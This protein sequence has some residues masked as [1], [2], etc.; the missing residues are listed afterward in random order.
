MTILIRPAEPDD[1]EFVLDGWVSS[2]RNAHA[3]GLI[4]MTNYH[5]VQ[6]A[7][8]EEILV[9]PYVRTL[10]ACDSEE[11]CFCYGFLVYESDASPPY[12]Y[13]VYTKETFRRGAKLDL[14]AGVATELFRAAGIDPARTFA[15]ACKTP[16]V[17]RLAAKI[18][19]ARWNPLPARYEREPGPTV[20]QR[21][22]ARQN[23]TRP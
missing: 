8:C 15:F 19:C 14:G 21:R 3:A 6:W 4:L 1:R 9:R 17:T 18:P 20:E 2:Y 12:V 11:P 10:V 23:G 5:D 22:P 7:Q 13:Y 16:I